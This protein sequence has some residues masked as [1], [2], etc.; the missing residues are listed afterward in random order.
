MSFQGALEF[1]R[2]VA[3]IQDE[4][5]WGYRFGQPLD[6]GTQLLGGGFVGVL[7]RPYSPGV[8]GRNP[9]VSLEAELRDELVG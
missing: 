3:G 8:H 2:V 5:G 4:D 7:R 1:H 6:Q 9:R